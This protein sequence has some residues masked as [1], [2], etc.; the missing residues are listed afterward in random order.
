M[1][2]KWRCY[3]YVDWKDDWHKVGQTYKNGTYLGWIGQGEANR[4]G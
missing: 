1:R 2:R 4:N 3:E